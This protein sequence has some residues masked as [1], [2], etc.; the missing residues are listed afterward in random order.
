MTKIAI[1][2][3]CRNI[4]LQTGLMSARTDT[5]LAKVFLP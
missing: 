5:K 4:G 1:L 2:D 3:D